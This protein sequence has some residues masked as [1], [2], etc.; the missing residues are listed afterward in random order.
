MT[1]SATSAIDP[2]TAG[3][4]LLDKS[5]RL[6]LL[7]KTAGVKSVMDHMTSTGKWLNKRREALHKL[8]FEG[9]IASKIMGGKPPQTSE[10]AEDE[11]GDIILGDQTVQHLPPAPKKDSLGT[12]LL[13]AA[14]ATAIASTGIGVPVLAWSALQQLKPTTP[15]AAPVT[16]PQEF[17]DSDTVL[18]LPYPKKGQTTNETP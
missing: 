9:T 16:P 1:S 18:S 13:K 6:D 17:N 7:S 4:H 12:T 8:Q 10:Q 14:A 2:L 3:A 5:K 11:M 15:A